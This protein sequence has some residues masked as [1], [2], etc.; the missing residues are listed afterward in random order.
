[1]SHMLVD[2]MIIGAQ[3]S[4]TTSLAAQISRHPQISFCKEKE[5]HFFSK[6]IYGKKSVDEYHSL[7]SR[8]EGQLC[9]EASTSY[10]LFPQ[11]INVASQVYDY[12]PKI[13]LIYIVRDP[14]ERIVSHYCHRLLK[15]AVISGSIDEEVLKDPSYVNASRY[16]VQL[17]QY[18]NFFPR[19]Q[20][21]LLTF[22]EFASGPLDVF[23]KI[24]KFLNID[25]PADYMLEQKAHNVSMSRGRMR[26]FPG[27]SIVQEV[28]SKINT[29]TPKWIK[30][31]GKK[32]F[33]SRIHEKPWLKDET[34]LT[35]W[36][37]L[38][39]DVQIIEKELGYELSAWREKYT[40]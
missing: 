10:T 33:I 20:I 27:K 13:R 17:R 37:L 36:A 9:G 14:V 6:N 2:F 12:N 24:C 8:S 26:D 22:N 11:H 21:L 39:D 34:K 40:D 25:P 32:V 29:T 4:A 31:L 30:N 3:K 28:I 7:Y 16:G 1:M 15:K 18:L 5:P 19:N 35:L 23:Q 38:E